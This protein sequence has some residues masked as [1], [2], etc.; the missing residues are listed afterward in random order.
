MTDTNTVPRP[1]GGERKGAGQKK[2]K[3][4]SESVVIRIPRQCLDEV[5]DIVS[6]FKA[7]FT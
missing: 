7:G 3:W 1:H 2:P 4:G 6:R 5:L